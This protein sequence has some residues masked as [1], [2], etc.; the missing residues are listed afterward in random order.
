[1]EVFKLYVSG[2]TVCFR[3][4]LVSL[5]L[6]KCSI[7][8]VC[9]KGSIDNLFCKFVSFAVKLLFLKSSGFLILSLLLP[10]LQFTYSFA[11]L[12]K[13]FSLFRISA[14]LESF[15]S[16]LFF[17]LFKLSYGLVSMVDELLRWLEFFSKEFLIFITEV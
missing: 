17:V 14:S 7:H 5:H 1:M 15:L 16:Q 13:K 12:M 4:M 3:V 8:R 6:V 9:T 10:L 2:D 11:C